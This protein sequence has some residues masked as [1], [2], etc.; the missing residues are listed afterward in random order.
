[1]PSHRVQQMLPAIK[2]GPSS[3]DTTRIDRA[4]VKS[5]GLIDPAWYRGS[6][7][8]A[9][10]SPIPQAAQ[11]RVLAGASRRAGQLLLMHD[12]LGAGHR[13]ELERLHAFVRRAAQ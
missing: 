10:G 2:P 12:D 9:D 1:Y 3:G 13:M 7:C 5:C 4:I 11:K 8:E 6:R